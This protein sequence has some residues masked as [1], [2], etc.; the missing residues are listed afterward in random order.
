M[1][2]RRLWPYLSL[3][4]SFAALTALLVLEEYSVTAPIDTGEYSNPQSG[5]VPAESVTLTVPDVPGNLNMHIVPGSPGNGAMPSP[6]QR[7]GDVRYL[8]ELPRGEA[9]SLTQLPQGKATTLTVPR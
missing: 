9:K 6:E 3:A 1:R 4:F 2:R 8:T 7:D 5:P